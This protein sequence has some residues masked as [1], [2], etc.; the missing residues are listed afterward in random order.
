MIGKALPSEAQWEKAAGAASGC[1]F[2]WGPEF[3]PAKKQARGGLELK[4]KA[5]LVGGYPPNK[6][7]LYDMAGNAFEWVADWYDPRYYGKSPA[8]NPQGPDSGPMKVVRGS[9]WQ[10]EA[11]TVRIFTRFGSDPKNRNES[12]GFR[13]A[14]TPS[15]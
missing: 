7:G 5:N 9:G 2:P 12:T 15:K 14:A 1:E 13:C 11:P 3:D 10:S 6:Y 4:E 8:K